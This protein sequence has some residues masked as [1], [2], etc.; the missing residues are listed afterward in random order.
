MLTALVIGSPATLAHART[1]GAVATAAPATP[2]LELD[3][4][5]CGL[6]P[7][8]TDSGV[9]CA[10]AGLPMD[11]DEPDG[12]QVRIAVARVPATQPAERIGSLFFNLGGPGAP[13]AELLQAI[14]SGPFSAL[15]ARFDIV[16]FDPRGT[17]QSTPAVDCEVNQETEGLTPRP[18]PIPVDVDAD[19]LVARAQD[20]VD[21]CL[22]N[23]GEILA[24]LSTANVARDMDALRAAVGD[25]K[26][27]YLG[28]SYG[29]FLGATY[30]ALFPDRYRAIVLDAPVDAERYIPDPFT[31]SSLQAVGFE[32][33]LNRFLAACA[34][35]QAACAG[36]GN[37]DP[38]PAYDALL[39]T[40]AATPIPA[41]RYEAD[42]RPVTADDIRDVTLTLLYSKHNWALLAATLAQAEDG[43][44]SVVRAIIDLIVF[45]R[46]ED[47]SYDPQSDRFFAIMAG[48]RQW[49]TDVEAYLARGAQD[50]VNV[51]HFWGFAY[52]EIPF[53]LWPVH[54]ED[55]YDGPFTV[56]D[57][58]PTPLVIATTYDPA[59]PY[60][61][62]VAMVQ[63]LGNARLVTMEGDGHG[64]YGLENSAC[65]DA[66]T[67]AYLFDGTV[68]AAGT[69]CA[70]EVPFVGLQPSPAQAAADGRAALSVA[71]AL[72]AG[73]LV[74]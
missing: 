37:G 14:G 31:L 74:R 70:Q 22:A 27:S 52:S 8:G 6:T 38:G 73:R 50:W 11:Y 45:P 20:Y 68:P 48:E 26:L 28:Y 24:H 55:A 2:A 54:D 3:W 61:G 30:A 69:V 17:G 46:E 12:E 56:P 62:G 59:T 44:A 51:P 7:E 32:R 67:E 60:A 21:S 19:A 42:P 53:A 66:A 29:T 72:G 57:S 35:D 10:T 49:P 25:E 63:A 64:A 1:D 5:P 15:N 71:D 36:F 4:T 43:D 40:A 58:S 18:M 47:G 13:S 33:A 9:E 34:G 65:V 39:A 41:D 23:N 16:G